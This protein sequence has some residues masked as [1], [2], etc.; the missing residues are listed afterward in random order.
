MSLNLAPSPRIA[1]KAML[2]LA[3]LADMLALPRA[4]TSW[5]DFTGAVTVC[6]ARQRF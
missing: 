4:L 5:H 2:M 1:G 6:Y 3:I